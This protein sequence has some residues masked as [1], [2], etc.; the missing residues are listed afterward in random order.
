MK[1]KVYF[2]S[3][4]LTLFILNNKISAQFGDWCFDEREP[5]NLVVSA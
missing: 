5:R 4:L 1:L 2:I 3:L